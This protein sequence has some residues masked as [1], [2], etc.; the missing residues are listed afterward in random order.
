[1][2]ISEDAE[3]TDT[4]Q[5]LLIIAGLPSNIRSQINRS[6]IESVN[7]L[8]RQFANVYVEKKWDKPKTERPNFSTKQ[9][10][11]FNKEPKQS[12]HA[13]DTPE[14]RICASFNKKGMKHK[15]ERCWNRDKVKNII[16][17]ANML[18]LDSEDEQDEKKNIHLNVQARQAN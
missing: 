1:M 4:T 17:Q 16:K 14:C 6:E 9:H 3:M 7:E 5:I 18:E 10:A 8:M 13:R 2:L 11:T 12:G 15:E